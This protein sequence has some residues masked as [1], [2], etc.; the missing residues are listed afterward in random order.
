[1]TTPPPPPGGTPPDEPYDQARD[2][3]A[4]P[5]ADSGG[6]GEWP[7]EPPRSE[8]YPSQPAGGDYR[9]PPPPQQ[10]DYP[11]QGASYQPPPAAPDPYAQQSG[12]G[13]P[14]SYGAPDQ[15]GYQAQEPYTPP[16]PSGGYGAPPPAGGAGGGGGYPPPPPDG[17]YWPPEPGQGAP[18]PY[19]PIVA[20]DFNTWFNRVTGVFKRSWKSIGLIMLIGAVIPSLVVG[21]VNTAVGPIGDD[22][23]SI[24]WGD[25]AG[26]GLWSLLAWVITGFLAAAAVVAAIRV[27]VREG[28]PG[29]QVPFGE[30]MSYGFGR[31]LPMWGWTIVASIVITIGLCACILP[32]IYLAIALAV[33]APAFVFEGGNPF[34]RSFKLTHS[35]FGRA[36]SRLLAA[37]VAFLV[38]GCIISLPLGLIEGAVAKDGLG[39]GGFIVVLILEAIR[40]VLLVP[41]AIAGVAVV[42]VTYAELRAR[43]EGRLSTQQLVQ[44]A[45]AVANRLGDGEGPRRG[46]VGGFL[47]GVCFWG[48]CFWGVCFWGVS[49]RDPC[50][51]GCGCVAGALPRTPQGA[52]PP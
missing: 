48:V 41:V 45:D 12:H 51:P 19:D 50:V 32:G 47:C 40:A 44:E 35:D 15:G 29:V 14:G 42:L 52:S 16:P 22:M 38:Y 43:L 33:I 25:Y 30:S 27:A 1:M 36:L 5:P 26:S 21:T 10:H 31:A 4:Q 9:P 3:H 8:G 46:C 37:A 23:D 24:N 2:P 11:P 39:F 28:T 18:D 17:P 49:R 34:M 7:A 13:E 20:T 6:G